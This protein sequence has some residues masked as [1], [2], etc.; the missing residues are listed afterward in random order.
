MSTLPFCAP[1]SLHPDK[2]L[3]EEFLSVLRQCN[4]FTES[5]DFL[6]SFS[7]KSGIISPTLVT[8]LEDESCHSSIL[9]SMHR[10]DSIRGLDYTKQTG[11]ETVVDS[12]LYRLTGR[13]QTKSHVPVL[14][15]ENTD[16]D[17]SSPLLNPNAIHERHSLNIFYVEE[18]ENQDGSESSDRQGTDR[19]HCNLAGGAD[20]TSMT[21]KPSDRKVPLSIN[22][23][24]TLGSSFLRNTMHDKFHGKFHKLVE[25]S[26]SN[27]RENDGSASNSMRPPKIPS[28]STRKMPRSSPV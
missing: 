12:V 11:T 7:S 17:S 28:T 10:S 21:G 9:D 13:R 19:E 20:M 18:E 6:P 16:D 1:L 27:K 26:T 4:S 8:H 24:R 25:R 23:V 5:D 15:C 2:A 3:E 14:Q 22:I